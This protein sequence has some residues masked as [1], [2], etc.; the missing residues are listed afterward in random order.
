M[1]LHSGMSVVAALCC[2]VLKALVP[3]DEVQDTRSSGLDKGGDQFGDDDEKRY[4]KGGNL[5]SVGDDLGPKDKFAPEFGGEEGKITSPF[6]PATRRFCP[7]SECCDGR[8][9]HEKETTTVSSI[10][11]NKQAKESPMR[12]AFDH[13]KIGPNGH[14]IS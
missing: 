13:G 9:C 12:I 7:G 5:A 3:R 10:E 11:S 4:I 6:R 14:E 8:A 1:E 2:P